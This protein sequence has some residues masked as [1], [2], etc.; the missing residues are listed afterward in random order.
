MY[1]NSILLNRRVN[2]HGQVT[3]NLVKL[4]RKLVSNKTTQ[5]RNLFEVYEKNPHWLGVYQRHP[6]IKEKLTVEQFR[7]IRKKEDAKQIGLKL[8]EIIDP[9]ASEWTET[10]KRVGAIGE[11][12]GGSTLWTKDGKRHYVTLVQVSEVIK[13]KLSFLSTFRRVKT[14]EE[15][16]KFPTEESKFLKKLLACNERH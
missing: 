8:P 12:V 13:N 3:Y 9:K 15:I 7:E 5:P 1:K 10:S 6:V 11:K 14:F 2:A 16:N 4:Q